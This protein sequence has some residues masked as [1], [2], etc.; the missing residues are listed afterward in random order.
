M[1]NN[2]INNTFSRFRQNS[3]SYTLSEDFE[4]RVFRKIKK[5][6]TQRKAAASVALTIAVFAFIFIAQAIFS[7]K[8]PGKETFITRSG[9]GIE[10]KEEIPVMEDVIFASSDR[11]TNYAIEQVAYY[12]DENS[13]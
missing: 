1:D 7:H 4:D 2:N 8:E 13:I 5:K 11:Q 9:V 10:T 6:K 3:P 12:E